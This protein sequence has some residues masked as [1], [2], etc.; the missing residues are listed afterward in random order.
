MSGDNPSIEERLQY[1]EQIS[2][3]KVLRTCYELA[4]SGVDQSGTYQVDPDGHLVGEKPISVYCDMETGETEVVHNSEEMIKIDHCSTFGC[5]R[6][7][8]DYQVPE[9]QIQALIQL[10]ET[11]TQEI[12][13][14]C[15]LAPLSALDGT[16]F[17]SWID[18]NGI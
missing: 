5:F 9:S 15:F 3:T 8:V 17:G 11:C 2:K 16:T 10:S 6:H 4:Q 14:G 18:K 1:V 13:F 12:D 7:L